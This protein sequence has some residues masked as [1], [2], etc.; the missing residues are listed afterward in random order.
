MKAKFTTNPSYR[1]FPL[2]CLKK[3]T[4]SAQTK[5]W[6]SN[7]IW[8]LL[9]RCP[10]VNMNVRWYVLQLQYSDSAASK[11]WL[12]MVVLTLMA[13]ASG[14]ERFG[15]VQSIC[16]AWMFDEGTGIKSQ[17]CTGIQILCEY[18]ISSIIPP[19]DCTSGLA[20]QT[21]TGLVFAAPSTSEQ[22]TLLKPTASL[23]RSPLSNLSAFP[24]V[25][26]RKHILKEE[27]KC[28]V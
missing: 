10:K 24:A 23:W 19:Y 22:P 20:R 26:A 8:I 21:L 27:R 3:K 13:L 28:V 9:Y 7:Q 2:I 12:V 14:I 15:V 11:N 5:L 17:E 18:I 6:F 1:F 4:H 25:S 16:Y